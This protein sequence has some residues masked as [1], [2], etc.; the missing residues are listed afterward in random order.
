MFN[1]NTID[2]YENYNASDYDWA[3]KYINNKPLNYDKI[4]NIEFVVEDNMN[5]D[6]PH[7]LIYTFLTIKIHKRKNKIFISY[8]EK[9][10]HILSHFI[11]SLINDMIY[12]NINPQLHINNKLTDFSNIINIYIELIK[13]DYLIITTNTS[14]VNL[15]ETIHYFS[16]NGISHTH[17]LK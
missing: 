4:F 6:S 2:L 9:E 1:K 10:S 13:T 14:K 15:K 17:V 11:K 3:F 5:C 8:T 7:S 16:F 12:D